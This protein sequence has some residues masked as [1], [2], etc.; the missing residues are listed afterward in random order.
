MEK[1]QQF[2][3]AYGAS[4]TPLLPC[5]KWTEAEA[6]DVI[7]KEVALNPEQGWTEEQVNK[8]IEDLVHSQIFKNHL[9][10]VAY[11][12]PPERTEDP[13]H[14]GEGWPPMIHL[15]IKRIDR[16]PVHDW[17]HL[18]RI[19]NELVGERHEAIELYPAE[20]R[21]VNMANQYHLW[22]VDDPEV[23][24]PIGFH[25]GRHVSDDIAA[26]KARQRLFETALEQPHE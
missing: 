10:Q 22:V 25:E 20:D 3:E 23:R 7:E 13:A 4:W 18:Q 15:S 24:F 2:A 21:M 1:N 9:Y 26:S 16:Q 5:Q 19:K 17:A 11:Y 6:R 12:P 14:G 8:A